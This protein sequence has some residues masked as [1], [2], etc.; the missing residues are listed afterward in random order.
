MTFADRCVHCEH[1][2]CCFC[3]KEKYQVKYQLHTM[4]PHCLTADVGPDT[5]HEVGCPDWGMW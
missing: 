4:C 5:P 2:E 1:E 3:G